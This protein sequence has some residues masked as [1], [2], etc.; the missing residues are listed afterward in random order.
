MTITRERL[1]SILVVRHRLEYGYNLKN[2]CPWEKF[3]SD[4]TSKKHSTSS[5]QLVCS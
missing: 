5:E 4:L 3:L 1:N 2:M